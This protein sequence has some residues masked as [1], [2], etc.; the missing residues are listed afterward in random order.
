MKTELKNG[1]TRARVGGTA[2]LV[3]ALMLLASAPIVGQTRAA[4]RTTPTRA[5][6]AHPY[7]YFTREDVVRLKERLPK[8][9]TLNDA[10]SQVLASATR[11]AGQENPG[12]RAVEGLS[13]AYLVT[14]EARYAAKVREILLREAARPNWGERELLNRTPPWHAGLE[15]SRITYAVAVGFDSIYD[16][17]SADDRKTVARGLVTLGI[18]PALNDWLIGDKRIHTLDSMGHNWWSACVFMAGVG[19]LAVM[20][21][22]PRA[23]GWLDEISRATPEWFGYAGSVLENKPRSFDRGGGFYESVNYAAFGLSEY[24]LFRLA[25]SHAT[26]APPPVIPLLD[27]AADFYIHAGYPNAG[28]LMSVNFGDGSLA[29]NGSRPAALLWALGDHK[30]RY[31]WYLNQVRPGQS[32]EGFGLASPLGLLFYPTEA[33]M[34]A[35]PETPDLPTSVLYG[36]MGWA[37][38]RSSWQKDATLLAVKSGLTWNHAHADN[39]SFILFHKGANL[40]IDS[41]NSNYARPEYDDYYRQSR[42]HNVVLF[43]GEGENPEDTYFG[44]KTPG[45]AS[46]LLDAGELKYVFA[47]ATGPVAQ[48]FSRNFRHFLWL[49]DV[50]LIIDDLKTHR[51]GQFE[52]LLHYGGRAERR[53]LDLNISDGAARVLVR[54]L[55][56]DTFPD[57]GLPTDYPEKMRLVEKTGFKDHKPDTKV[58]YY[59]FTPAELTRRTKFVT[60]VLLLDE[61]NQKVLPRI[62]RLEGDNMIGVRVRQGGAVTEVYLNLL[63]DGRIM[64]RNSVN[65]F[66]GWETDAYLTAITFPE[67][68]DLTDPDAATRY[69]VAQGSYLR[70]GGKT[71]LDS[72]SK[73]F[74][75]WKQTGAGVDVLLQGQPVVRASV[76]A[77]RRP[78]D[79]T[80]N[81][82]KTEAV[83]NAENKTLT[84][85]LSDNEEK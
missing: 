72:L 34:A 13:L 46:H 43:N 73:V 24:L 82:R 52:W 64:H 33:E 55:F 47:D 63:A 18:L 5:R 12:Y 20:D 56:P 28:P 68:A 69:F 48:N 84:L 11:A 80:L 21:E 50:I 41:G 36:D 53:G 14:G 8:E 70:R 57:A 66:D 75:T 1:A 38:L 2:L 61:K 45:T 31:L 37:M 32:R 17:L 77:A 4:Q 16:Y 9:K 22:E 59:A 40:I 39:G 25:W 42:A 76:R 78:A 26:S 54:P 10:W 62:E 49:G 83:Y 35:A 58:S 23:R 30:G 65:T 27:R 71:L 67:G 44:S 85:T 81:D 51:P 19:A 6:H 3:A 15:T 74:A 29:S 7:L 79:V 60:A